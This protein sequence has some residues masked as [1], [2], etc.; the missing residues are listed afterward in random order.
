M[1]DIDWDLLLRYCARECT[2]ADRERFDRWLDADRRH[3]AFFDVI[4]LGNEAGPSLEPP[5]TPAWR[6]GKRTLRSL[7]GW[8]PPRRVGWALAAAGL[9]IAAVPALLH[10]AG[11][12]APDAPA[13]A[14]EHTVVTR[15]GERAIVR[16]AD[17][18]QI[19]VAAASTLRYPA[20]QSDTSREVD[21]VGEAYFDV[22]HDDRRPFIVRANG[23]TI[24]DLGTVFDVRAYPTER[25]VRVVVA[26]GQVAI[27]GTQGSRVIARGQ[28]AQLDQLGGVTTRAVD[29]RR[30]VAWTTGEL[31]FDA[32]PLDDV[33]RDLTRWYGTTVIVRDSLLARRSF[34]GTFDRESLD[35]ILAIVVYSVRARVVPR[36]DTILLAPLPPQ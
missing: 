28:L 31:V 24:T 6:A 21:V 18:T 30:F 17:G 32:T 1:L 7:G 35:Q 10:I 12:R 3:R 5:P 19:I 14:A 4:A 20:A 34:T 8:P 9:V 15:P 33:A 2:H 23:H 13:R 27:G 11:R 22:A 25:R 29:P 16:M 26:E 36:G